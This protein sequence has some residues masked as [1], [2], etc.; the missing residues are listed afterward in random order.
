[1]TNKFTGEPAGY[2]FIN[3]DNDQENVIA[4]ATT[5]EL[6]CIDTVPYLL[7]LVG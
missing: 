7:V 6:Q 1:M 3:F 5:L 4:C 2:G